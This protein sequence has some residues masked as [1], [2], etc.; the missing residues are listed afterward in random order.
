MVHYFKLPYQTI[1]SNALISHNFS[2]P[3]GMHATFFS[4]QVALAFFY[5]LS[6][7]IN[8][9]KNRLLYLIATLILFAGIIQ[10]SSKAILVAIFIVIN[11]VLPYFLI[12]ANKRLK[13]VLATITLSALVVFGTLRTHSF[14][15]RYVTD[16]KNDLS[17]TMPDET[18]EPRIVR[19]KAALAVA[20]A[21]PVMGYGAGAE[22]PVLQEKYFS[23]KLYSAFINKLN[24]HNEYLT[25]LL[26]TGII[27]L[28][29]YLGT[30]YYG[31]DIAFRHKDLLL[32]TFLMLVITVS[33]SESM[34]NAEKGVWFY[35]LFLSLF[36]ISHQPV[37]SQSNS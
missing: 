1:F 11:I 3:I 28:L 13:F 10:L 17:A 2:A 18:V 36:V 31:F 8:E 33:L 25:F 32:F 4:L 22:T 29:V 5:M 15:E 19:W 35:A 24:A 12:S 14:R 30:L 34:L 9:P 7:L 26:T 23:D 27:G 20:Q 37:Q 6:R 16:L 21:H